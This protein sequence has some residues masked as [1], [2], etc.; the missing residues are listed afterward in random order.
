LAAFPSALGTFVPAAAAAF[1][2]AYPGVQLRFVEAEPP[3]ALEMLRAGAVEV[4]VIFEYRQP[5]A[6]TTFGGLRRVPLLVEPVHLVTSGPTRLPLTTYREARWIGGCERCREHL[7]ELCAAAGFAPRIAFTTDDYVAVQSLVV[8]DLG[9][10][11]LPALALAAHRNPQVSSTE[12]PGGQR[13]V[14]A[15]LYGQPPDPPAT[16]ALLQQLVAEAVRWGASA[17]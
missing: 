17:I 2:A 5:P 7:I 4:A 1:S 12:L 3:E 13:L 11:V 10:A 8:A 6:E 14:H 9:V 15:A 16:A